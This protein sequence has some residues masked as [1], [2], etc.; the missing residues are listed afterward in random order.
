M[1]LLYYN[2]FNKVA[3]IPNVTRTAS[4][5]DATFEDTMVGVAPLPLWRSAPF[6]LSLYLTSYCIDG[7]FKM[8]YNVA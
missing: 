7:A 6:N 8:V 5:G 3:E 2:P 4:S 1:F